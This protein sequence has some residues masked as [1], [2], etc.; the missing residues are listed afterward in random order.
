MN[1]ENNSKCH[2]SEKCTKKDCPIC[3]SK[4]Q[5]KLTKIESDDINYFDPNTM[6]TNNYYGLEEK[7][8]LNRFFRSIA[9][10]LG[11]IDEHDNHD[12]YD[13]DGHDHGGFVVKYWIMWVGLALTIMAI[14]GNIW[15]AFSSGGAPF[16]GNHWVEFIIAT[17]MFILI[18]I[19]FIKGS[20]HATM[21]KEIGE[22][23]LVAISTTTAYLISII[24]V[25]SG[26]GFQVFY[27]AVE[28]WG[29]IYFGR[30]LEEYLT[31]RVTNNISSLESLK[32]KN[33]LVLRGNDEIE[34]DINDL[35]LGDILIIKPGTIIPVDGVV[36]EGVTTVD[37]SSLTG[38]SLPI[39]K[40][41]GSNVYGGTI[42]STGLI[43]IEATKLIGDSFISR[44]IDGVVDAVDAKPKSQ[45][46]A[47]KIAGILVPVVLGIAISVFLFWG[48]MGSIYNW[49]F[50]GEP[51]VYALKATMTV[52][53]I[54]CP[55]SFALMTP[56][57]ILVSS[58]T[59]KKE[60]II[61]STKNIFESIT[62]VNAV[63]FDKTGTLTEGEF[64][65][66]SHTIPEDILPMVVAGEMNSNHPLAKSI[67][68]H[69]DL[70]KIPRIMSKEIIGKGIKVGSLFIGSHKFVSEILPSFKEEQEVL[71]LR[72]RGSAIVYVFDKEEIKGY[73]ELRDSIK[74]TALNAI[75]TL[76]KMGIDVMMITGDQ[77][78][79]AKSI[80][81]ELGI[82]E[83]HVY[84][85]VSPDHKAEIIKSIQEK[86]TKVAYVGDGINDSVALVQSNIGIAIGEG[87]DAA[88]EAADIVLNKNDL[89][90]VPY[91]LGLS[92]MTMK[93]IHRGFGIAI[94]YN[95][96][97][98][99][100]A[101]TGILPP[102]LGALSMVFND[103]VAMFNAMTLFR[104]NKNRFERKN[105]A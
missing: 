28:V 21:N 89:T 2:N 88:I 83:E 101:S 81:H 50:M 53:V 54:A 97:A 44:I 46:T 6:K 68:K 94:A 25:L 85:E 9:K 40:D 96:I 5:N 104:Y 39:T 80:A 38:E 47:D 57:S 11:W 95:V 98:I 37:E 19:S 12:G 70:M 71:K 49:S 56:L 59:S 52:M 34:L 24:A 72:K 15:N 62:D 32:P 99:P 26:W 55:C 103:S 17:T 48:V 75:F 31:N 66:V 77:E 91:A 69:F 1:K 58:S 87:S 105:K 64:K 79:T 100:L 82:R 13:I 16:F 67:V 102:A 43:K 22:D 93:T 86:G 3:F 73:I 74:L 29:L 63:A 33:A 10:G 84:F 61:F 30:A 42:S 41:I 65:V 23:T 7:S 27:E 20:I 36:I 78:Q 45:R 35:V 8:F 90:L 92:K 51:W 76:Q 4:L 60:S 18:G 14:I